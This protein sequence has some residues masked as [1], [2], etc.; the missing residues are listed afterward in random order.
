MGNRM[1]A[2]VINGD[3]SGSI[4]LQAPAAAGSTTVNIGTTTG[5][6]QA[7]GPAFSAYKTDG[8]Q[9]VTAAT[10]TKITFN[11][12][13]FDTNNCFTNSRFTPTVAG[14]YQVQGAFS[15]EGAGSPTR[16]IVTVEKNGAEYCRGLDLVLSGYSTMVSTIV[17]CNGT[18]DY[19]EL[20]GYIFG[21]GSLAF[22]G[23]VDGNLYT[24]FSGCWI[25]GA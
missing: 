14:Y 9:S 20:W 15:V 10:L 2:L 24:W 8:N 5:T 22:R 4:T 6:I 3:T 17:Y 16:F 18:T 1:T 21:S 13:V 19:L 11:G 25:R 12:E 23:A 7:G